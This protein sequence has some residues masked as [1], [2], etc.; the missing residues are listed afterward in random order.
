MPYTDLSRPETHEN[1]A[2]MK[3]GKLNVHKD[4]RMIAGFEWYAG[5]GE[6]RIRRIP[7]EVRVRPPMQKAEIRRL[8]VQGQVSDIDSDEE[9][10]DDENGEEEDEK[11]DEDEEEAEDGH[12]QHPFA[13]HLASQCPATNQRTY[14]YGCTILRHRRRKCGGTC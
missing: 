6:L 13:P 8:D 10:G 5:A 7:N 14:G 11:N 12:Y 1:L 4:A 3:E 9:K 2:R